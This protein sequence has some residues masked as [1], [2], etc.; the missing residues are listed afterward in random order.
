M[1]CNLKPAKL[2]GFNSM[3]MVLAAS[4]QGVPKVRGQNPNAI[5]IR[6]PKQR[7]TSSKR[8]ACSLGAEAQP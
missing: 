5:P 2:A 1:V 4:N 8:G 6:G 7:E 3:G